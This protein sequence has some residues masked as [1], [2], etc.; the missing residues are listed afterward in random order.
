MSF[1]APLAQPA[2]PGGGKGAARFPGGASLCGHLPGPGTGNGWGHH[3]Q[4][5]P[6]AGTANLGEVVP[7]QV[8]QKCCDTVVRPDPFAR[9]A[10]AAW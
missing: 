6:S 8:A 2:G 10:G 4:V 1:S 9:L 7:R 5:P 3:P